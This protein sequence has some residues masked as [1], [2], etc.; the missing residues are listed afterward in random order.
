MNQILLRKSVDLRYERDLYNTDPTTQTMKTK[1]SKNDDGSISPL[2]LRVVHV[3]RRTEQRAARQDDGVL[4]FVPEEYL[5]NCPESFSR[6][7]S[8]LATEER[9]L[10]D[11]HN[12]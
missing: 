6:V 9:S 4:T 3:R 1:E 8:V 12:W 10:R 5:F 11:F 2:H 7:T